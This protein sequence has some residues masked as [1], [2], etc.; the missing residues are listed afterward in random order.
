MSKCSNCKSPATE[1]SGMCFPCAEELACLLHEA[2]FDPAG[3]YAQPK[4]K[5]EN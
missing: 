2:G 3:A 5:N 1:A 4:G